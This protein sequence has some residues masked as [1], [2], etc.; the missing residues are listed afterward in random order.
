M[1]AL[2][3]VHIKR[4]KNIADASILDNEVTSS[5]SRASNSSIGATITI[6]MTGIP[7]E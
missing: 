4:F 2:R 7:D 3:T 6:T 5:I 1:P